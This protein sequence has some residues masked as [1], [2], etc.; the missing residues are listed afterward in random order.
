[1]AFPE[2]AKQHVPYIMKNP[3]NYT[4]HKDKYI[5]PR[6]PEFKRFCP[7]RLWGPPSLLSNG[8][9]GFFPWE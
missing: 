9:Q 7:E 1:M 2:A 3:L 8:Y 4:T 5:I 6:A